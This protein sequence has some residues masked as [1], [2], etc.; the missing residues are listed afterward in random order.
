MLSIDEGLIVFR[1][2]IIQ[3]GILTTSTDVHMMCINSQNRKCVRFN[4]NINTQIDDDD[5]DSL[6]VVVCKRGTGMMIEWKQ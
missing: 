4:V 1:N 2:K 3:V 6:V 5:D